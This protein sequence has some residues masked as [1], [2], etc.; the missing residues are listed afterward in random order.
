MKA[1]PEDACMLIRWGGNWQSSQ[2]MTFISETVLIK[3]QGKRDIGL[4][5]PH[6]YLFHSPYCAANRPGYVGFLCTGF[7]ARGCGL[8]SM[9][10]QDGLD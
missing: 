4:G 3:S 8:T 9:A 7:D 1:C 5:V 10:V 2:E 6:T